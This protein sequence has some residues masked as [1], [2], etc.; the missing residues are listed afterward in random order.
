MPRQSKRGSLPRGTA[1]AMRAAELLDLLHAPA[2]LL[3]E[4]DGIVHLNAA[5]R[6]LAG[7]DADAP[8][9]WAGLIHPQDRYAAL[10]RFRSALQAEEATAFECRLLDRRGAA[11]WFLL[12]FQPMA[13]AADWLCT[14]TDIHALKRREIDL[15]G[16]ASIQTDMLNISL[17]CIKL[18]ALDGTLVHMNKAGCEALGVP[19]DSAFGM[20]WL[21]LLPEETWPIGEQALAA[22]R[23]GRFARFPGYSVLPGRGAQYWD[24]MLTPV[25]GAG[26]QATAILCVSREITAER[27]ALDSLRENQ[28]R[29]AI[30]VGV[31]GLG[32]WDYDIGRD[33]LY[34]DETWYRIMGLDP[35]R[36]VRS[37]E[38]FQ[39]FIHPDD[40]AQATEV[41]QT[42]AELMAANR[43]YAITFRIVRPDGEVRWVR[44][45]ACLV[46]D[47]T[48][49]AVR[50]VGFVLDVTD[51][52]RGELALRD[53]NRAL[54]AEKSWLAR[55]N[56][57]D[58]LTGIANRRHL[59]A[60][61]ERLCAR[62]DRRREPVCIGM[63]DVDHFKAYNDRYGHPEGD[64][65]LRRVAQAL[66]GVARQSD[67]VA[68][69]GGE[70]FAFVLTGLA[71]P[72]PLL[73]RFAAAVADLAIPHADSPTGRLTVSCG[74]AIFASC[75][76]VSPADLIK[77]GDEALYEAKANGR[78]RYVIRPGAA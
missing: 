58:A 27:Q 5:W 1:P 30:A 8:A 10:S 64:A 44:S 67:F 68:R 63:I 75:H 9:Q 31:G 15:Q 39:P 17:D 78:N 18:I 55:Q 29:L 59:D 52:R 41:T 71:D 70:E 42:A 11:R 69:Y 19:E 47:A 57:E 23:A 14:A 7:L 2:G 25:M 38:E 16:R 13:G 26:G 49:A 32:I 60:E 37:I 45:A 46:Q 20:P 72:A 43:D 62:A 56:L 65:A 6:D 34:C 3:N 36:P 51:A 74:C 73:A 24:N 61:L 66:H 54:Q 40:V 53:A 21:P 12:A 50:A 48:G 33:A 4:T 76:G 28:E 35:D 77:A 22:A